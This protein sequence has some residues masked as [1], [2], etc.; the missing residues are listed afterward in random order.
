MKIPLKKFKLNKLFQEEDSRFLLM[1]G[2][3]FSGI[4][5]LISFLMYYLLW[6]V[7][8]LNNIYFESRGFLASTGMKTA[9]FDNALQVVYN[10]APQIMLFYIILF[11]MGIYIGRILLRPFEM[12]GRYAQDKLDG[13]HVEF[14]PDTF[15]DYKLMTRFAEFFFRYLD[16]SLS[17]KKLLPNTIPTTYSKIH[18]P[19]FERVFFFHF[20]L[21]IGIVSIIACSSMFYI[22]SE[23]H[24]E[25]VDLAL[26]SLSNDT[27]KIGYFFNEQ[28]FIF[29]SI[30]YVSFG[31]IL[32][33][34]FMLSLHLYSKVSGAIFGFFTTMRS[35]MK[36]N[37]KARIHLLGYTHVRPHSRLFNKY[38]DFVERECSSNKNSVK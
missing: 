37:T 22:G 32:V 15:S 27:G 25:L 29:D 9:F 33:G 2:F 8:S 31:V 1:C 21:F 10:F 34:Y 6:I 19:V 28:K 16:E 12:I 3:K 36:G 5:L 13:G 30:S 18:S 38:L 14:I 17:N 23:I 26:R 4:Y 20:F 24:T 35:F 7:L 11:F